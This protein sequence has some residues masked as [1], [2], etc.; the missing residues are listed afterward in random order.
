MI[1][2]NLSNCLKEVFKKEKIPKNIDNLKFGSFNSWD[3]LGH[4]NLLLSIEKKFKFKFSFDE[5]YK[6]K[7][8]KEIIRKINKLK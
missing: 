8:I 5:M 7:T 4:V 2:K 1:K 3:S 6:V